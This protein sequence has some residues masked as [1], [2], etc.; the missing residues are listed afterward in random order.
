MRPEALLAQLIW[1]FLCFLN[2]AKVIGLQL[3]VLL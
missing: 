2:S 3:F 1:L